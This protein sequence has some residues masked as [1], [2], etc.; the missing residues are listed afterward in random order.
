MNTA[1]Q[2]ALN[3]VQLEAIHIDPRFQGGEY[4]DAGG[5]R[6]PAPRVSR[7]RGAWRC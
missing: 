6:R 1:D 2:I 5:R 3:S 7:S 4:Y